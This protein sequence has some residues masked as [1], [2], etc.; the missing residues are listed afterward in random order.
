MTQ[1]NVNQ[2]EVRTKPSWLYVLLGIIIMMCLGTVYSWSVFRLHVE[3]LYNIGSTQ[4]G[5]PY[6][7]SLA[8]Y[9]IF[10][11]LTGKFMDK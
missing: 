10:M 9:A 5:L 4:S 2:S 3:D 8:I 11:I 6:M 7:V 1:K